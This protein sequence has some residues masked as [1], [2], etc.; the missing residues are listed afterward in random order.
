V[1]DPSGQFLLVGNQKSDSVSVF[2]I[3][4][5]TGLPS[6][7]VASVAVKMPACLKFFNHNYVPSE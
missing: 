2:R 4:R 3:D 6:K 1:I 7:T 5:K